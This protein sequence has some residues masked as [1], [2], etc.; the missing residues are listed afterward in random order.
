M[1]R[2]SV[3][4]CCVAL[5]RRLHFAASTFAQLQSETYSIQLM[6]SN[7]YMLVCKPCIFQ[8]S[9]QPCF[10]ESKKSMWAAPC[11]F[12]GQLLG[13]TQGGCHACSLSC[14]QDW[15][16]LYG[17]RGTALKQALQ[18]RWFLDRGSGPGR[19]SKVPPVCYAPCF[20]S[21]ICIYEW[22]YIQDDLSSKYSY[23]CSSL[24]SASLL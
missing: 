12:V 15:T 14:V 7:K 8:S 10:H 19:P 22:A 13:C 3:L 21:C 23:L 5:Q 4:M 24:E 11:C 9:F 1:G 17:L 20:V 18:T 16:G 6:R 2:L